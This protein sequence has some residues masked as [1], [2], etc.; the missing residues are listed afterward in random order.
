MTFFAE[1][2]QYVKKIVNLKINFK[3]KIDVI[4]F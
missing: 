1:T 2:S 4:Y 3:Q